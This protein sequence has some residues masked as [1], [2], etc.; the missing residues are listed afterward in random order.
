MR[1]ASIARRAMI[2]PRRGI[3]HSF[4]VSYMTVM[5][6]PKHFGKIYHKQVVTI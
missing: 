6:N 1:V 4:I 2:P 5:F 3:D